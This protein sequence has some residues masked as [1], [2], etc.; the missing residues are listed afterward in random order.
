[1]RMNKHKKNSCDFWDI[2][3][4]QTWFFTMVVYDKID[5]EA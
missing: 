3:K 2:R 4:I 1:M 5:L